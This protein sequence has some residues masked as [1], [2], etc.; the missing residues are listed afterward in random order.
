MSDELRKSVRKWFYESFDCDLLEKMEKAGFIAQAEGFSVSVMAELELEI[1]TCF[2]GVA[3]ERDAALAREAALREELANTQELAGLN[4]KLATALQQRLTVTES[5]ADI[6][7]DLLL[8][9]RPMIPRGKFGSKNYQWHLEV[10]EALK[11][12]KGEGP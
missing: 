7:D 9:A 6:M 5:R 10:R 8:A 12:A 4:A 3:D 1:E 11:P 2:S